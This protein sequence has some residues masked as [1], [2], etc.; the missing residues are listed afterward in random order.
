[1]TET[2][3]ELVWNGAEALRP[4]LV[5]VGDLEPTEGNPRRGDVQAVRESL[6]RFGQ[7]APVVVDAADGRRLVKGH[8]VR[9]AAIE[10]GW[11]HVAAL[12]SG[13]V[14]EDEALAFLL[15]DNRSSDR[16]GYDNTD[17][18]QMLRQVAEVS[19]DGTGYTNDDLDD[20]LAQ[21]RRLDEP[22][23]PPAAA[24]VATF[25]PE[26]EVSETVL[27]YNKQQRDQLEMWLRIIAKEKGTGGG[28]SE[29]IYTA[30]EIAARQLNQ[31]TPPA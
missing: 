15:A 24:P 4:F 17:L 16:G 14:N 31:G 22:M 1:M 30:C 29:T 23:L 10:L 8:H 7:V 13:F 25:A 20:L 5:A 19:L 26:E 3:A 11:T 12:P 2:A 27:L 6:A 9:L 21:M 28:V 18:L